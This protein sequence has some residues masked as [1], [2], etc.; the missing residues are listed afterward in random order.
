M[1]TVR[2]DMTDLSSSLAPTKEEKDAIGG[3]LADI[4]KDLKTL[5][6]QELELAK[7]EM[8]AEAAKIG[9]GAGMLGGAGFAALMAVVFLSTALWWALANV[10]DQSWAALIVAGV[11]TLIGVVLFV[12]GRGALKS[13]NLKPERTLNS[14]KQLPA[15]FKT[16]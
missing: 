11:W 14:M 6:K 9:K 3:V 15:A 8:T 4:T 1:T 16:R 10:M 12:L 5:A 7:A 13:I 2:D